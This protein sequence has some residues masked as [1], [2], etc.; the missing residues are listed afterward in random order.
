[1]FV[2]TES[3]GFNL[4]SKTYLACCSTMASLE[5]RNGMF[6]LQHCSCTFA[7]DMCLQ[8]YAFRSLHNDAPVHVAI[9]YEFLCVS[10]G[11]W[12]VD[13]LYGP[14]FY[15][16]KIKHIS[17]FLQLKPTLQLSKA[18]KPSLTRFSSSS[19]R[20]RHPQRKRDFWLR[21][22][23][24][25]RLFRHC[26]ILAFPPATFSWPCIESPSP[27]WPLPKIR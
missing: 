5:S 18:A 10:V 20:R 19:D 3:I 17:D 15:L 11:R 22:R 12:L 1:M 6:A 13:R 8:N 14:R 27:N 25:R 9:K 16:A 26:S 7:T 2:S 23:V 24:T 4:K 21:Q